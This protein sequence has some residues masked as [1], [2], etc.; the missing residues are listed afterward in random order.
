MA[1]D[2]TSDPELAEARTTLSQ[3]S[4]LTGWLAHEINNSLAAIHSSFALLQRLI[5]TD[6]PHYR[7]VGAIDREVARTTALT[8]RLQKGYDFPPGRANAAPLAR[9]VGSALNALEPLRAARGVEVIARGP[10]PA[11]PDPAVSTVAEA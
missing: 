10:G 6:H 11:D 2:D 1:Q 8:L 5:P 7:Y 9:A 4:Q 3:L